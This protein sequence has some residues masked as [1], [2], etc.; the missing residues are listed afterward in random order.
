MKSCPCKF[1]FREILIWLGMGNTLMTW[2]LAKK[3]KRI[4]KKGWHGPKRT[5]FTS[6]D[7]RKILHPTREQETPFFPNKKELF[8]TLTYWQNALKHHSNSNFSQRCHGQSSNFFFLSYL[9]LFDVIHYDYYKSI[10]WVPSYNH[11]KVINQNEIWVTQ[12]F[13][14]FQGD[15]KRE[16]KTW[17]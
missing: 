8:F 4:E 3:E 13:A 17:K 5:S 9:M 16:T 1:F 10:Q 2:W 14:V 7:G 12:M 11:Q 15:H 6:H